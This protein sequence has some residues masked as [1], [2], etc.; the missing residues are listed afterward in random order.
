MS[1]CIRTT[2]PVT[3]PEDWQREL[4]GLPRAPE[5]GPIRLLAGDFNATFDYAEFRNIV[6]S[7]YVDAADQVGQGL[8][9][10][11]P[12]RRTAP[13]VTL[14]HVLVDGRAAVEGFRVADVPGSDHRAVIASIRLPL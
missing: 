9:A 8:T 2:P 6:D 12:E 14:D 7:G 3:R 13:P 4:R 5:E 11:W 1:R 10:T